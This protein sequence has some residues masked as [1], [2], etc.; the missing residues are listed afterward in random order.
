MLL[1]VGWGGTCLRQGGW[2]YVYHREGVPAQGGTCR[3]RWGYLGGQRGTCLRQGCVPQGRGYLPG[4]V[5]AVRGTYRWIGDRGG[6]VD[7]IVCRNWCFSVK[8][9]KVIAK[10]EYMYFPKSKSFPKSSCIFKI[11]VFSKKKMY[12][13]KCTYFPKKSR[14]I[15]QK[16]IYFSESTYFPKM[17]KDEYCKVLVTNNFL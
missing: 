14:C 6:E 10:K 3:E 9:C 12:S 16:K 2:W 8:C 15:L 1:G 17:L 7:I 13:P 4:G 5:P 11:Y